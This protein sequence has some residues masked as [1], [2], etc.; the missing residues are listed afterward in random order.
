MRRMLMPAACALAVFLATLAGCSSPPDD[1]FLA[2]L[3]RR[4]AAADRPAASVELAVAPLRDEAGGEVRPGGLAVVRSDAPPADSFWFTGTLVEAPAA[5]PSS[6]PARA[7][8]RPTGPASQP[9]G[10]A[11]RP[12][13]GEDEM[14]YVPWQKRQGP[15]YPGNFWYSF[16]RWGKEMPETLWDDTKATFTNGWAWA[17][18]A[19]AGAAGLA[20]HGSADD[21]IADHYTRHGSQLNT[22]WDSVGDAGGNPGTHFA[23]AGAM[24]FTSLA[25]M[26]KVNYEKATTLINALAINGLVTIG[27]NLATNSHSPNGDEYDW[28]SGHTSS[29]FTFATVVWEEYGPWAGVPAMLFATYVGYERIDAR[30]HDFSDVISGALIGVAIGYA[31]SQN[32]MPRVLG[33][34]IVPY[35]SP[36]SGATGIAAKKTW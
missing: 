16:G 14:T 23:V 9:A 7:A 12:A 19:A 32:H 33:F 27:L 30:N 10:E 22:F 28:P 13:G 26:D 15:A 4:P 35:V 31:V 29:S 25:A 17:G 36:E 34:D 5:G 3:A 2:E 8:G 1:I 20:L 24:Y 21:H 6:R 11:N 18:F